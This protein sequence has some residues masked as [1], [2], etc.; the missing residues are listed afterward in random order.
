VVA[1]N[2]VSEDLCE[3][4]RAE[5]DRRLTSIEQN[6][7][8][9]RQ[10]VGKLLKHLTEGN[11]QPPVLQRLAACETTLLGTVDAQKEHKRTTL[12][13]WIAVVGWLVTIALAVFGRI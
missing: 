13:L 12:T 10:G 4:R 8:E 1:S 9:A 11:G 6:V 5:T 7:L 2:P 3:A